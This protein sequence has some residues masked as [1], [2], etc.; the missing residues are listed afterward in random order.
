MGCTFRQRLAVTDPAPGQR[1]GS[2]LSGMTESGL[3]S[4]TIGLANPIWDLYIIENS[5]GNRNTCESRLWQSHPRSFD[6]VQQPCY[7][8]TTFVIDPTSSL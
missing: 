3:R 7:K 4:P 1:L 6:A 8:T 2:Y 5:A